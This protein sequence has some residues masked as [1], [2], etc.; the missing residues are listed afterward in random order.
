[1]KLKGF[2]GIC[3]SFFDNVRDI[4]F[5]RQFYVF[6]CAAI[7]ARGLRMEIKEESVF[8]MRSIPPEFI[9]H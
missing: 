8:V 3:H 1:M 7:K 5:Y 2:V 4:R 6:I 9:L